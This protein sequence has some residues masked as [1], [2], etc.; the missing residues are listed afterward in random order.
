M[1][2]NAAVIIGRA[3]TSP[4]RIHALLGCDG[5]NWDS[6]RSLTTALLAKFA[7]QEFFAP[8]IYPEQFGIEIFEPLKF[9]KEPLNQ[10][11]MRKDL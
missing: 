3:N 10:F 5:K 7:G 2:G 9:R 4:V 11:L 1:T 8:A 6:F